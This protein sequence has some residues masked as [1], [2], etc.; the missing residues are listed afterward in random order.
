MEILFK[1]KTTPVS[2]AGDT[3]LDYTFKDYFPNINGNALWLEMVPYVK[4]SYR[5]YMKKYISDAL[6]AAITDYIHTP[7]GTPID[8]FD[9]I[10]DL[11]CTANAY[12]AVYS[13]MPHINIILST[14]G[15]VEPGN[16]NT[17]ASSQWRFKGARWEAIIAADNAMDQA[18][19]YLYENQDTFTD[20]EP[21]GSDFFIHTQDL[22]EY[23]NMT[24]RRG[25]VAMMP[26]VKEAE[27]TI[28]MLLG[29]V[30]YD[31]IL[32]WDT[33]DSYQKTLIDLIK[34]YIADE[35]LYHAIP[36]LSLLVD[37]DGLK[38]V[39]NTDN[40]NN[41]SNAI[42]TFGKGGPEAVMRHIKLDAQKKR[43]DITAYLV[44]EADQF[45][46]WRDAQP[47]DIDNDLIIKSSNY[48]GAVGIG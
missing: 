6:Y 3:I 42:A 18:L 35:S 29:T 7:P 37:G 11:L 34:S 13:A 4:Q 9:E 39:S 40:F 5:T 8:E 41:Y 19:E 26:Y 1:A 17:Q 23:L 46:T 48:I 22:V 44:K 10:V 24:G 36:R 45:I 16:E 2:P 31:E 33:P 25:F 12:Y 20:F 38:L 15:A 21:G 14:T 30:F 47:E 28:K 27:R 32:G 43:R